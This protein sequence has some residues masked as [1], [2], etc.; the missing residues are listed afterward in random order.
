MAYLVAHDRGAGESKGNILLTGRAPRVAG[1]SV[2]V[3]RYAVWY[4]VLM[5]SGLRVGRCLEGGS[6]FGL[7]QIGLPQTEI[8]NPA[9]LRN[10]RCE[11]SSGLGGSNSDG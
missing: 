7:E 10:A 9:R 4:L 11:L 2:C 6:A 8:L 1:D 5:K 3:A